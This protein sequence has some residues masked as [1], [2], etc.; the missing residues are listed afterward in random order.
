M[1]APQR[2]C[3]AQSS[4]AHWI[5]ASSPSHARRILNIESCNLFV[6]YSR[7]VAD[8]GRVISFSHQSNFQTTGEGCMYDSWAHYAPQVER[9]H[10]I[11]TFRAFIEVGCATTERNNST[12]SL[13]SCRAGPISN[14]T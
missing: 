5:R 11:A 4:R 12:H 10:S 9:Q 13:Q 14:N 2:P 1:E 8:P 3:R 7:R 6:H